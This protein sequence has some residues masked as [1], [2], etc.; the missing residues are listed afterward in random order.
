MSNAFIHWIENA[1]ASFLGIGKEFLA[2]ILPVLKTA[3]TKGIEQILPI[4]EQIVLSLAADP[5]KSGVQ[6]Q[7][8]A[9]EQ[10]KS[11]LIAQGL[12]AGTSVVNLAIEFAV[13]KLNASTATPSVSAK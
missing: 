2:E 12:S 13:Q 5:T 4:A 8:A 6:K 9:A 11:A 7:A 3:A 1:L 10:I